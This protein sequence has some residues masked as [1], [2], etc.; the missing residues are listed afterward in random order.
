VTAAGSRHAQNTVR[1]YD[2]DLR[3]FTG[4]CRAHRRPQLPATGTDVAAFLRERAETLAPATVARRLAAIVDAHRRLGYPSPRD[5]PEVRA[6]ISTIDWHFR[7]RRRPTKPLDRESLSR[8]SLCLPSTPSG[9]RDRALLLVGYGAGLRRTEVVRLDVGDLSVDD[10]RGLRVGTARGAVWI[11]RGSAPHLCAIRAWQRWRDQLACHA[12]PA[13]RAVDQHGHVG[14]ARLS[15]RAVTLVVRRAA[16]QAGLD[17]DAYTGRSLRLGLV[18]AAASA[19]ANDA[20]IMRQTG[21]RTR[22]LVRAYVEG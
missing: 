12:G 5:E 8:M 9:A 2:A 19:G 3:D 13:F 1:G 10:R 15:D 21:H 22:R 6:A 17:P 4:W 14:T 7:A 16:R 11:P 18:L 20:D